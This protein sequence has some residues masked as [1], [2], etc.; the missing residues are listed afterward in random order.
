MWTFNFCSLKCTSFL[1]AGAVQVPAL[2]PDTGE[3]VE[4]ELWIGE[5][6]DLVILTAL[7]QL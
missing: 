5:V 2:P 4:G 1:F 6:E 7:G 3:M